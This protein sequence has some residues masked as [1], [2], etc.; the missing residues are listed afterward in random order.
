MLFIEKLPSVTN[1][2]AGSDA[3]INCP[4]GRTYE[5]ITFAYSGVT[6]AQLKNL[7]VLINGRAVWT[8]ADVARLKMLNAYHGRPDSAGFF[9]LHFSRPELRPVM[10]NPASNAWVDGR[11]MHALGTANVATLEVKIGIDAAASSPS[12]TASAVQSPGQ[13]LGTFCKVREFPTSFATSGLQEIANLPR[14]KARVACVHLIKD[15]VSAC[16]VVLDGV[17]IADASKA[18]LEEG[19]KAHGKVPQ[20]GIT[21][22]DWIADND[23]RQAIPMAGVQDFRLRPTIDTNGA[24]TV[25]VEYFDEYNGI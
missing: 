9:T 7:E 2:V 5:K 13:P 21:H 12:L 18:L 8:I 23:F 16:E 22:I 11:K 17:K 10:G 20:S 15:D 6:D 1:V 24:L 19:Q 3:V 25:L 14:A 4:V